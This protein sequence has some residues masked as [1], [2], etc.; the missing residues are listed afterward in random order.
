MRQSA[1]EQMFD[2]LH[3]DGEA[4]C[5]AIYIDIDRIHVVN[6]LHGFEIGDEL[7][8]RI[9]DLL[10]PPLLPEKALAARLSG[11]RGALNELR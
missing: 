3:L 11:D 10:T 2:N 6:E 8:V 4:D 1:L 9:A 7:I 5:T